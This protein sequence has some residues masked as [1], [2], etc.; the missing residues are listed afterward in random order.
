MVGRWAFKK[1]DWEKLKDV[2]F[3][4]DFEKNRTELF[5]NIQEIVQEAEKG[6]LKKSFAE[7]HFY[8]LAQINE[9]LPTEA[10]SL[11]FV[12]FFANSSKTIGINGAMAESW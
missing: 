11:D 8:T 5:S 6:R 9:V 4:A 1:R 3:T 12:E 2:D 10:N 7:D